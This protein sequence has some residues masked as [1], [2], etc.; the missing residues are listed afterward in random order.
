M[1]TLHRQKWDSTIPKTAMDKVLAI[2]TDPSTAAELVFDGGYLLMLWALVGA[3]ALRLRRIPPA[4]GWIG[5]PLVLAFAVLAVGDTAH[6]GL[7]LMALGAGNLQLIASVGPWRV[8]LIG[9]GALCTAITVTGFY[10]L[11]LLAHQ[12]LEGRPCGPFEQVLVGVLILRLV[13]LTFPQNAWGQVVPPQPWSLLRNLPLLVLTLGV[14]GLYLRTGPEVESRWLRT[15]GAL[16]L[17]SVLCYLPVVLW[18]QRIPIL[19]LLMIPKSLAYLAIALTVY[20]RLPSMA[21]ITSR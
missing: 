8:P 14:G 15:V 18:I 10:G 1:P 19:G 17:A 21:P 9:F 20:R 11:L 5:G 13:V 7:R 4:A 16:L 3:M 2:M 12:R 6:V